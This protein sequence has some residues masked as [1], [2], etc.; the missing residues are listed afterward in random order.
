V[1]FSAAKNALEIATR[2]LEKLRPNMYTPRPHWQRFVAMVVSSVDARAMAPRL[3]RGA[4]V[5][6]DR[7]FNAIVSTGGPPPVYLVQAGERCVLRYVE[8]AGKEIVLRPHNPEAGMT[9]L[10][11]RSAIVGRVCLVISEV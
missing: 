5:V 4:M 1:P 7:H 2:K 8:H 3:S 10:E 6:I 11:E 9:V